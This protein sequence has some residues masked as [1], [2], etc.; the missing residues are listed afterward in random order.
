MADFVTYRGTTSY[1][2][3]VTF[4][5]YFGDLERGPGSTYHASSMS[6]WTTKEQEVAVNTVSARLTLLVAEKEALRIWIHTHKPTSSEIAL[7]VIPGAIDFQDMATM[8]L[9]ALNLDG[10]KLT[11][12]DF[13]RIWGAQSSAW[14]VARD[15]RVATRAMI[16]ERHER[17]KMATVPE[18]DA[19]S[20]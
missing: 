9:T 19:T 5:A 16:R 4:A 18:P 7:L 20:R 1:R 12:D 6:E 17:V 15:S 8:I 2:S 14:D 11:F 13:L 10:S 3:Y